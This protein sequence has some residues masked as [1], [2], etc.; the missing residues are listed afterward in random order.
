VRP[1]IEAPDF[2]NKIPAVFNYYSLGTARERAEKLAGP[3]DTTALPWPPEIVTLPPQQWP[4]RSSPLF[5]HVM[6]KGQEALVSLHFY[7]GAVSPAD[8]DSFTAQL[9]Q[10]F[11]ETVPA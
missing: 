3:D 5:L 9:F 8:Q 10:V 2:P 6:D 7:Q 1:G 4:R 11:A